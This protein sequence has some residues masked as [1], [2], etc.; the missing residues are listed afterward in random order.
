MWGI[1]NDVSDSPTNKVHGCVASHAM[2]LLVSANV[3]VL[4]VKLNA[5]RLPL[6]SACSE[7]SELNDVHELAFVGS[8][9]LCP[10]Q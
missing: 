6:P 7:V 8:E 1:E 9:P 3:T 10:A 2:T 5:A 4:I